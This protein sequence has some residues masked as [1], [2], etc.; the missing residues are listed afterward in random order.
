MTKVGKSVS[1]T[2]HWAVFPA[3]QHL[4]I[5]ALAAADPITMSSGSYRGL[6]SCLA[7]PPALKANSPRPGGLWERWFSFCETQPFPLIYGVGGSI[8]NWISTL[9][10]GKHFGLYPP[11][12][13]ISYAVYLYVKSTAASGGNWES[14][15]EWN[16]F[17]SLE[18]CFAGLWGR[19]IIARR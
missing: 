16:E 9:H 14:I 8:P 1:I 2:D 13:G 12:N 3:L 7:F 15:G 18:R 11:R 6:L 17:L 4:C 10:I 5:Y 19:H